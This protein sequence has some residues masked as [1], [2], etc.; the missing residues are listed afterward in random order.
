M[1]E[2]LP[3]YLEKRE[4]PEKEQEERKISYGYITFL[5]LLAV[6]ITIGSLLTIMIIRK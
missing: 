6:I 3:I 2:R 5:N 1:K 4:L